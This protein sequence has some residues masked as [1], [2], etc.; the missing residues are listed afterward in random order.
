MTRLKILTGSIASLAMFG[1]VATASATITPMPTLTAISNTQ[2]MDEAPQCFE[3]GTCDC[4][5][6]P[7]GNYFCWYV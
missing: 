5:F 4:I 1:G 3:D 7:D 6:F 2:T